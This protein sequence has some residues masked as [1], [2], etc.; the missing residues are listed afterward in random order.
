MK[1]EN[2]FLTM[3]SYGTGKFLAEFMT[4]AYGLM[5]YYFFETELKLSGLFVSIATIIYSIWNAINDP[6]IGYSTGLDCKITRKYGRRTPWILSGLVICSLAFVCIFAV[7]EKLTGKQFGLFVWMVIFVCLYDGCYSVWEVNY[8][9]VFP[10]KFRTVEERTKCATIATFIGVFGIALG[11]VLP[12]LF[13]T[14]GDPKS[15]KTSALI[16]AAIGLV[17]TLLIKRGVKETPEM[18]ERFNKKLESEKNA[19]FGFFKSLKDSLKH[20][21]FLALVIMLFLYQS[22]CMCM[23]SSVNYVAHG[24]LGFEK[25]SATTPIFAGML[26]GA[27]LSIF[28]W[29]SVAKKIKNNNQ[30]LLVATCFFMSAASSAMLFANSQLAYAIGMFI[31]GLGFGGYWTFMTPAMADVVDSVV[32]KQKRRD[33][34]ILM[35][36]RAFFMRL[37]YASQAIVFWLC[38]KLTGYD[39]N[40]V[41]KQ[42]AKAVV[43]IKLHMSIVPALFFVA[44]ALVM[45]FLNPLTPEIVADNKKKLEEMDL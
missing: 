39:V 16:I 31:W 37:S 35:G 8:Q 29:K 34:G 30:N 44:A 38:H 43:G 22:A 11:S 24:V 42:S 12:P 26:I 4:G 5:V 40:I 15:F 9:G 7:P 41:G 14:Y 20:K 6:L 10:D 1:E 21:E 27:L 13:Y 23:T 2:K 25:G 45:L 17:G 36:V 19:E 18:I 28:V 33:D 3:A 32:V